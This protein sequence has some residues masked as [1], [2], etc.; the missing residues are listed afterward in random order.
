[1]EKLG[2]RSWSSTEQFNEGDLA[3]VEV[4]VFD[5]SEKEKYSDF[6]PNREKTILKVEVISVSKNHPESNLDLKLMEPPRTFT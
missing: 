3:Y 1:M 2:T 4:K 5:K 6:F